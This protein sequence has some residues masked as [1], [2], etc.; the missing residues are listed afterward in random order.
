MRSK[1]H[2]ALRG[3]TVALSV[4]HA[5]DLDRG[6]G[7]MIA[8]RF[9][10]GALVDLRVVALF[11]A[12]PGFDTIL[13]PVDTLAAHTTIGLPSQIL[14]RTVPAADEDAVKTALTTLAARRPGVDAADRGEAAAA[15]VESQ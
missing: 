3:D 8:T 10:D 7:D 6:P 11:S 9:G 12:R 15:M 5:R 1:R 4:D 13:L 14:V 2:V